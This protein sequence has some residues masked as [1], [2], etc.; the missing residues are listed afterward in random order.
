MC[1]IKLHL[2]LLSH[3]PNLIGPSISQEDFASLQLAIEY[4]AGE[5]VILRFEGR[6]YNIFN[7]ESPKSECAYLFTGL[8]SLAKNV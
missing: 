5:W 2:S 7:F 6:K 3:H 1:V 4:K 8:N